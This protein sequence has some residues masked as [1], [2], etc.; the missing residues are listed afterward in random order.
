LIRV[1]LAVGNNAVEKWLEE[2]L[3]EYCDF[4]GTALHKGQILQL[5]NQ[6]TPDVLILDISLPTDK[7]NGISLDLLVHKIKST[8]PACRIILIAGDRSPGDELLTRMVNKGVYDIVCGSPVRIQDVCDMIFNPK[9]YSYGASLLQI[10]EEIS[11]NTLGIEDVEII[12]EKSNFQEKENKIERNMGSGDTSVLYSQNSINTNSDDEDLNLSTYKGI[13][14]YA[15]SGNNQLVLSNKKP[16]TDYKKTDYNNNFSY[17]HRFDKNGKLLVFASARDGVGCT[18]SAINTAYAFA[19]MKKTVLLIDLSFS[20]CIYQRLGLPEN[21]GYTLEDAVRGLINKQ[22]ISNIP[23]TK[24]KIPNNIGEH[25]NC[26]PEYLSFL[27]VSETFNYYDELLHIIDVINF[28]KHLYDYIIIDT[29]LNYLTFPV[30]RDIFGVADKYIFVTSQDIFD[31]NRL[32]N[33]LD[34]CKNT[35]SMYQRYILLVNKYIKRGEPKLD[36]ISKVF[37]ASHTIYTPEDSYEYM[38]G[39]SSARAYYTLS[40]SNIKQIYKNIINLI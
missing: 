5:I 39:Y 12:E 20:N 25:I 3:S 40:K 8:F 35:I 34:I 22:D 16:I 15:D 38:R 31:I 23:L 18:S 36:T 33:S 30:V 19:D 29:S 21:Y 37:N 9:G 2:K 4:V 26:V 11:D 14:F 10:Y 6:T 24:F 28:Y 17:N 7:I 13:I 1:C 27:S 32:Y